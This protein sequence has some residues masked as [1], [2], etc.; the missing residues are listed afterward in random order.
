MGVHP[1]EDREYLTLHYEEV[2]SFYAEAVTK[3][4]GMLIYLR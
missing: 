1:D 4:N 2:R 3:Q